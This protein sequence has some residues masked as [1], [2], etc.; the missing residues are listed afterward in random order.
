MDLVIGNARIVTA[1][2]VFVGC[3]RVASGHIA[4]VDRGATAVAAAE[5]WAGDWLLPG[6]V[7]LHTDNLERHLVPRPGVLWNAHSAMIAHDAQCAAAGI[8]TVL[9]SVVIG[10]MDRGGP[11]SRT[12]HDAIAALHACAGEGL[13]RVEHRLHLRCEV[14]APDIVDAF[15]RYARDPL[16]ALA[17]VMD[18]TPGQ[19]QWSDL[20]KYRRYVERHGAVTD[21][22]FASLVDELVASQRN[23]AACHRAAVVAAAH[24]RGVPLASHDDTD[25][26]HVAQA[27][28][29]GM[30][31]AEFPTTIAA[32]GAA[33]RT[34]CRALRTPATFR[35]RSWRAAICSTFFPPI[36]CPRV[37]CSP[38][39]CCT[40]ASTGRCRKR[41]RP[42]AELP[43]ARSGSPT[44]ARSPPAGAPTCFACVRAAACR[45]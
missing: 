45:W 40:N 24:A 33:R 29:E 38:R 7:E 5:D 30:A 43:R 6:L 9:D 32:A 18:H 12:Q 36:T 14:A 31:L 26:E 11:R 4:A 10:D 23:H 20:A 44:A 16:L 15:E 13:L 28:A 41:S 34:S 2:E 27:E 35:R 39:S 37:C 8:T 25:V 3:V 21:A 1:D 19:R 22:Q 17:S 42:S